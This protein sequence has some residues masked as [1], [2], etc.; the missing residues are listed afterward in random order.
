MNQDIIGWMTDP[1]VSTAHRFMAQVPSIAAAF[2]LLLIGLF[3][4]RA[5]RTVTERLLS[6]ASLD[7]YTSKVGINEILARL[8][9]G[10]S[11]SYVFSFLVFWFILFIF[12][13]SA[14]NAVN[15]TVVSE[16]LE[17]F[18][19]FLPVLIASLLILFAGLLFGRFLSEIVANAANAN[20]VRGGAL[21]S[22]ATYVTVLIFSAMTALEQLG[23]KVAFITGAFQILIGSAGLAAGI[24]FGLGGKD[25]A[26]EMLR[27]A[28]NRRKP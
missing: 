14:A 3:A 5:L 23:M 22:Q 25:I 2:L 1:F 4:A 10:K 9:L 28:L 27:D 21:L 17:R 18:V 13:V 19:L 8:G 6:K 11:P 12:I 16:L 24:A 15:L 7:E 20:S 26:A